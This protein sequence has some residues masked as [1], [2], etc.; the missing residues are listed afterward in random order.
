MTDNTYF[1]IEAS[2]GSCTRFHKDHLSKYLVFRRTGFNYFP[3]HYGFV[4]CYDDT[5]TVIKNEKSDLDF[6]IVSS[7]MLPP[8]VAVKEKDVR[9][10]L[11]LVCW[12]QEAKQYD[13]KLIVILRDE[14]S[15]IP[16]KALVC[17]IDSIISFLICKRSS[18]I[19][20][21]VVFYEETP[22]MIKTLYSSIDWKNNLLWPN[23]FPKHAL[24][25]PLSAE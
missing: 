24:E 16:N 15:Q 2:K 23:D 18:F 19:I 22:S 3:A 10:I 21:N 17:F 7:T 6:F 13:D 12:D 1:V 9:K 14:E 20:E 11:K 5:G 4:E 25:E 8:G